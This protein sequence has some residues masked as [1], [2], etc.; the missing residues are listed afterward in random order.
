MEIQPLK[1]RVPATNMVDTQ[2]SK[3]EISNIETSSRRHQDDASTLRVRH[4]VDLSGEK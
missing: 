1:V 2:K 4:E 3:T